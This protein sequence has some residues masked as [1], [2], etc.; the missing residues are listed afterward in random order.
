MEKLLDAMKEAQ[1]DLQDTPSAPTQE[2]RRLREQTTQQKLP[3]QMRQNSQTLRQNQPRRARRQQQRIQ[4]RMQRMQSR[5]SQL[6]SQMQGR[7][8]RMNVAGLRS[9]LDNTLRLSKD[10]ESL[11]G[12]V[13]R[14]EA[15]GPAVRRYA[16]TPFSPSP[17]A[18]PACRKPYKKRLETPCVPCNHRPAP[19]TS[20]P[21]RRPRGRKRPL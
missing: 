6:K 19:W 3:Q 15:D 16:V 14:L 7:Q 5:L 13:E 9:A 17:G 8:R 18:C 10:Q 1:S 21:P 20:A 2:L 11:R 4:Q 12:R